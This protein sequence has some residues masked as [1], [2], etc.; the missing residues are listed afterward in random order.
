MPATLTTPFDTERL[1]RDLWTG[2]VVRPAG[3]GIVD[4]F[5]PAADV[6]R[7]GDDIVARF[8]L[9][10]VDPVDD[11]TV[12][13]EG[14]KLVVSGTR[15]DGR[16]TDADG[17]TE[18]QRV[19][20]VRFGAFRRVVTLARAASAENVSARYDAGVLEVTVAGVFTGT[21]PQRIT[22]TTGAPAVVQADAPSEATHE[23]QTVE[24]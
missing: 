2:R 10:G 22:V 14:R 17:H 16:T 9:P 18:R 3:R 20:E 8:D 6:Y 21:A 5:T 12:E 19:R 13:V 24:G 23:S 4:G 7:D 15:R 11:V 1:F